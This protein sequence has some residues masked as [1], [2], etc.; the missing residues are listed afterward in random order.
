MFLPVTTL[1][2]AFVAL[3]KVY[4]AFRII[5][6]RRSRKVSTGSGGVAALERSA[7]GH[8]NLIEWAPIA[9]IL[10]ALAEWQGAPSV[11]LAPTALVFAA[12]RAAHAYS[13]TREQEEFQ[14]RAAGMHM[15]IW[16]LIGL[17]V[18]AVLSLL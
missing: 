12:G 18:M 14:W 7:R 1:L 10:C 2:A 5:G 16:P 11:L 17:V 8:A 3:L 13:F 4:L 9:L 6:L 15:T